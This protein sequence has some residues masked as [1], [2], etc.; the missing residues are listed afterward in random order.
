MKFP[1]GR[2]TRERSFRTFRL[3]GREGTDVAVVSCH[4]KSRSPCTGE[5]PS[6]RGGGNRDIT[7][8]L[9]VPSDQ[10]YRLSIR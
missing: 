6:W 10:D 5:P 3:G 4:R 2:I 7:V 9:L 8:V 1:F